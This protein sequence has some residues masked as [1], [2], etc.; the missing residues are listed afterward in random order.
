[1]ARSPVRT[2]DQRVPLTRA[3]PAPPPSASAVELIGRACTDLREA[4]AAPAP[5]E[6]YVAAHLAA[7]RAGAAVL[8]V[9]S[10]PQGRRRRPV[11]VWEELPRVAPELGAWAASFAT[12]APRR[13]A[14]EAGRTGAVTAAEADQHTRDAEVF[15]ALVAELIGAPAQGPLPLAA[16]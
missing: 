11:N 3:V 6:R 7:L 13:A 15:T 9:R 12:A 8:A 4:G 5:G 16:S 1:V 10:V 2:P 14:V